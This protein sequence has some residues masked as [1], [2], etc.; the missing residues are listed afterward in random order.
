M[1]SNRKTSVGII[2]GR[3]QIPELTDPMRK[4]IN[5]VYDAHI[6]TAC[7]LKTHPVPGHRS[8]PL[9]F[10][11]RRQMLQDEYPDMFIAPI[12]DMAVSEKWQAALIGEIRK[13]YPLYHVVVYF[14]NAE[15]MKLHGSMKGIQTELL[16]IDSL[17]TYESVKE[18]SI[19]SISTVDFRCGVMYGLAHQY[20]KTLSTVDIGVIRTMNGQDHVLWGRKENETKR[21]LIGGFEEPNAK[22]GLTAE[23]DA[24]REL[25]EETGL[26]VT[27]DQLFF[28]TR[29]NVND[30]RYIGSGDQIRTTL[31]ITFDA[32]G[33]PKAGDD[34][35]EVGWSPLASS[36]NGPDVNLMEPHWPLWRKI[37]EARETVFRTRRKA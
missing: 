12:M 21:R 4:L 29:M 36:P 15:D 5:A 30:W 27:P 28:L 10:V 22:L 11:N 20:Y 24:A 23:E 33:T 37:Q 1:T 17:I 14:T 16:D 35:V 31:F 34:I 18:A 13:H 6:H 9:S 32:E 19:R 25:F 8:N 3:F 2:V 26:I 7:F